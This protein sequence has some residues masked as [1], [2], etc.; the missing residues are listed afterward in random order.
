MRLPAPLSTS[1]ECMLTNF[2]L[3]SDIN[4]LYTKGNTDRYKLQQSTSPENLKQGD[5]VTDI[6]DIMP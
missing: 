3:C 2:T 6:R 1:E 4:T 5:K